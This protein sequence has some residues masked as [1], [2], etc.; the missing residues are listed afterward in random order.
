VSFSSDL[1]AARAQIIAQT[2]Q[3]R[4]L[5]TLKLFNAVI[6]DTPVDTGRARGNWQ[7]S[8]GAAAGGAIERVDPSGNDA[9]SE[10]EAVVFASPSE[11]VTYMTNNLPYAEALEF[12]HSKQA[13]AGMVRKNMA[14]I[15]QIVNETKNK[16]P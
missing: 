13:P 9:M 14:R 8:L 3:D 6:S 10:A 4:K 12:G 16:H 15:S 2:D 5:I 7:T 11:G 1:K